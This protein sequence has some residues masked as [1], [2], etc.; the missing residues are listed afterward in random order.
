MYTDVTAK[1]KRISVYRCRHDVDRDPQ[2]FTANHQM[3]IL[4]VALVII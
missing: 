2:S 4:S 3:Q 1:L